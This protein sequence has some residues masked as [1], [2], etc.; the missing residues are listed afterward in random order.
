MSLVSF[1][2]TSLEE[3]PEAIPLLADWFRHTWAPFYGPEGPGDP[4]V[5]L[6]ACLHPDPL[7]KAFVAIDRVRRPLGTIALKRRSVSHHHLSPWVS[8]FLVAASHRG[9]GL[10]MALLGA[11]ENEARKLGFA[12]L[13]MSAGRDETDV[14]FAELEERRWHPFDRAVTLRGEVPV[15]LLEL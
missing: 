15:Y 6:R 2:L 11:V 5:D 3:S 12:R 8:A 4:E 9:R 10:G 1:T 7:P 14:T 13:H